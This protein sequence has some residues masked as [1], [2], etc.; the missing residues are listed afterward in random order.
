MEMKNRFRGFM[1]VVMDVETGGLDSTRHPLLQLA[2]GLLE[3]TPNGQL[4]PCPMQSAHII[5]FAGAEL[6]PESLQVN[7]IDPDDPERN[8]RDEKEVLM[9]CIQQVR[10]ALKKQSCIRAVLVG[11]NASFDHS[12]WRQAIARHGIKQNPFHLFST[13]D[14]CTL[15][16]LACAQTVLAT[17]CLKAGIDFDSNAAH[18]AAYDAGKTAELFC[19]IVNRW[20]A[21]EESQQFPAKAT[22]Q[23]LASLK[24]K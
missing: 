2:W 21:G 14:T 17:C 7:G 18:D 20:D 13:F 5:P 24:E 4:E 12:F 19:W 22:E 9:E 15:G 23:L 10:R 6:D 11:H 16:A 8:A 1:P 3:Y